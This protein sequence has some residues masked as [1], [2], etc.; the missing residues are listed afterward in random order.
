[1]MAAAL[2]AMVML[3]EYGA[4]RSSAT[5]PSHRILTRVNVAF[6]LPRSARWPLER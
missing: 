6:S 5:R 3:A 2:V 4:S 1:L